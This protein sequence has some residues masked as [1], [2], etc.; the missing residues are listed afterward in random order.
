MPTAVVL[1][2]SDATN[3]VIKVSPPKPNKYLK[4]SKPSVSASIVPLPSISA[5]SPSVA[6][7]DSIC[8]DSVKAASDAIVPV[9]PHF[10]ESR[11]VRYRMPACHQSKPH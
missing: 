2:A 7:R 11:E 6:M 4:V 10:D 1:V 5:R 8:T 9:T 3:P